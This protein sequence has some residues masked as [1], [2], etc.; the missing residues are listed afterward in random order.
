MA[1]APEIS[2]K[3][4]AGAFKRF[5]E[6]ATEQAPTEEPV[7]LRRLRSHFGQ[8]PSA[9]PV[10]GQ[11][12]ADTEHPNVQVAIDAYLE[13]GDRSAEVVGVGADHFGA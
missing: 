12:F 4:F 13:D 1:G 10:V 3:D 11:D 2:T 9:L 6:Q 8:D 7:F 5:L